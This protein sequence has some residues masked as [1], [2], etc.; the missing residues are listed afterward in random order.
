M[1]RNSNDLESVAQTKDMIAGTLAGF[2]CKIF[3]YPFDTLKTLAQLD[4]RP[5]ASLW[6]I[7]LETTQKDGFYRLFRGLSA[8]LF[9]SGIEHLLGFW[10]FGYGER[11]LRN[12]YKTE[13]LNIYQIG[14]AGVLSGF[15]GAF[16][17]TPIEYIKVQMQAKENVNK[18]KN[19]RDC[20]YQTLK[21]HPTK[22]FSG[23]TATII[24]EVPGSFIYFTSYRASSRFLL[25]WT[26]SNQNKINNT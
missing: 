26:E 23:L 2:L 17:L 1:E 12:Y 10:L 24:R 6:R 18:Y 3:E 14:M 21:N 16:W 4:S 15:G 20:I 25:D 22:L 9:G 5:N 8:P 19:T 7:F 13:H 11:Y